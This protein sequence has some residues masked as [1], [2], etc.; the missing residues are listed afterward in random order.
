MKRTT[1]F[2]LA[3]ILFVVLLPII[4]AAAI[5]VLLTL[6]RPMLFRQVRPGRNGEAFELRKFRTMSVAV[7]ANGAPLADHSR[8][9]PLGRFLRATGIDELPELWNVLRGDMSL[10]G[11]RPL[12]MEYLSLYTPE[13]HRRHDVRPGITGWAQIH[14]VRNTVPGVD[15]TEW[16][17]RIAYD[18]W[19]VEHRSGRIDAQILWV[20]LSQSW[21]RI[22]HRNPA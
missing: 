20:T 16:D 11:P 1:D 3:A 15:A 13:E 4:L 6:G 5:A 22:V 8:T 14:G 12:L 19:Y 18:L 9:P 10:V 7:D 2:A 17:R 21:H